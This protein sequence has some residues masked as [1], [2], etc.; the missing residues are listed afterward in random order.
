MLMG[1]Q[2]LN[3]LRKIHCRAS[4]KAIFLFFFFNPGI[5]GEEFGLLFCL[6]YCSNTIFIVK[7]W[8][9]KKIITISTSL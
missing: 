6:E 9:F 2:T 4:D 3:E 8:H 5:D 1:S 7:I